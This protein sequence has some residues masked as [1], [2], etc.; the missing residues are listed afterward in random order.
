MKQ[1]LERAVS[2]A[3]RPAFPKTLGVAVSGGGDSVALLHLLRD[4]AVE[5]DARLC[6]VTVDHCFRVES[7]DEAN[8][9]KEMCS[10]LGVAHETLRWE[11]WDGAGNLQ[12]EA[13]NAR[14]RLIASWAIAEGVPLVA[15][16]HTADDQAETV[17]MRLARRSGVDGLSGMPKRF[18]THGIDWSR[19]LLS[20]RREDLRDY[21]RLKAVPW[22][23]DPSN[24]DE[25]FDRIKARRA[26]DALA[27]LGID[28]AG[29]SV[30]A[31]N[32]DGARKALAWQSFVAARDIATIKNGSVNLDAAKYH[33][34]PEEIQRRILVRAIMSISGNEYSPRR[35]AVSMALESIRKGSAATLDG[36]H[37]KK[38]RENIC[39]FRE[40]AA[41]AELRCQFGQVWDDRWHVACDVSVADPGAHEVRALG[42]VG[43]QSIEKE[44]KNNVP[45]EQL[46]S[47]PSVWCG[48]QLICA[49]LAQP[50]EDWR[51]WC[52]DDADMFFASFLSH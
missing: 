42:P 46:L 38:W 48:D 41:V 13:R 37:V 34:L 18:T 22:K 8:F 2:K 12:N 44:K 10:Q 50:Q 32:M 26:L 40:Y 3:F 19:P 20:Q 24:E 9:V 35:E 29:L 15:L 14:Y 5:N 39:I 17:L 52:D 43:L 7:A 33:L 23:D 1:A 47:G 4:L 36:C 51:A 11:G 28:A 30:V 49:P 16:G 45:R 25:R 27:P 21:L 31:S 6:A